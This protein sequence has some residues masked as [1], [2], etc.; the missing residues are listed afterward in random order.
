LGFKKKRKRRRR[1]KRKR[2]IDSYWVKVAFQWLVLSLSLA[3]WKASSTQ[4]L[5]GTPVFINVF[6]KSYDFHLH[7]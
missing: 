2:K 4:Y 5:A 3:G 6:H 1:R 7:I